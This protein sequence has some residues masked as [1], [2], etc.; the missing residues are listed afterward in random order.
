MY[1]TL[2]RGSAFIFDYILKSV[3]DGTYELSGATN[4]FRKMSKTNEPFISGL[5]EDKIDTF[6]GRI[7]FEKIFDAG[8][9][10][11]KIRCSAGIPTEE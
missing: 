4:E 10:D 9:D 8:A 5:E 11:F 6:L 3:V 2:P 1:P 7:G